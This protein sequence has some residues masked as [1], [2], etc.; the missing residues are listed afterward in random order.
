M[1]SPQI[2]VATTANQRSISLEKKLHCKSQANAIVERGAEMNKVAM[3]MKRKWDS[4]FSLSLVRDARVSR[5]S[6]CGANTVQKD[7][8]IIIKIHQEPNKGAVKHIRRKI[9]ETA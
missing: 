9:E 2:D 1:P 7:T 4:M 3:Q 6:V 5:V 8:N